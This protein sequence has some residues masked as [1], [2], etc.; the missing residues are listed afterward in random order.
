MIPVTFQRCTLP[1][2]HSFDL[3]THMG[4]SLCAAQVIDHMLAYSLGIWGEGGLPTGA[5]VSAPAG[6]KG[7]FPP[8]AHFPHKPMRRS[9]LP[10]IS[11]TSR[12]GDR[13]S[14]VFPP[15]CRCGDRRSRSKVPPTSPLPWGRQGPCVGDFTGVGNTNLTGIELN[16]RRCFPVQGHKFHFVGHAV[17]KRKL[18]RIRTK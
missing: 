8:R 6:A 2:L 1:H 15:Q 11:P 14:R 9:A 18:K 16:N 7:G 5:P 3:F 12:C 13:R 4:R 17:I 10:R